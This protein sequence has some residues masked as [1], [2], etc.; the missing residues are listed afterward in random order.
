MTTTAPRPTA[1]VPANSLYGLTGAAYLL[2]ARMAEAA[3]GLVSDDPAIVEASTAQL[4]AL[5]EEGEITRQA[6]LEKADAW[7]WVICRIRDRAAARKAHA[8]RLLQLAQADERRAESMVE[9]LAE[10]LLRLEPDSTKF[11][12]LSH[13]LRSTKVTTVE[14]EDDLLA[15]DLPVEY[16][17]TKTTT[18]VDRVALKAALKAGATVPGCSLVE[19]RV[20]RMPETPF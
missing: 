14:I 10:R 8:A 11:F 9:R 16:Q 20:W 5:L 17:R 18:S 4:E 13:E 3:E 19:Q 6:I 1:A 2:E 15:E 7:G 12:L